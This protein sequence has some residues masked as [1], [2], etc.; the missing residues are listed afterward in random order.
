M[1]VALT[2]VEACCAS[3]YGHPLVE[4]IAGQSFHPG[5]PAG[6]RRLL[7]AAR[8][9]TQARILDAGC[10][11][12]ASARLAALEFGLVVDACDLSGAAIRR[13]SALADDA[14]ARVR[15]AE[16]SLLRLPYEDGRFA[17]VLAE[18]VLS[19]TPKLPALAELRRVTA[20]GGALLITDVTATDALDAPELIAAVL[21][22]TGAWRPAEF[23]DLVSSSGFEIERTWDETESIIALLDRVEARVG[24]LTTLARDLAVTDLLPGLKWGPASLADKT[25]VS[26]AIQ[27]ARRLVTEGRIGYRAVVARAVPVETKDDRRAMSAANRRV[28]ARKDAASGGASLRALAD[29][30]EVLA[31]DPP[32][33]RSG[34]QRDA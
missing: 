5:G 21:C 6:T 1:T 3:L 22:L 31:D 25:R 32:D 10:G 18:C 20:A 24:L 9:P 8:L 14:G 27:N 28:S 19:T 2:T 15:F 12:G 33:D 13:A 26:S 34:Q 29:V 23:E 4:V 16:A 17:G 7:D 11:L 30:V